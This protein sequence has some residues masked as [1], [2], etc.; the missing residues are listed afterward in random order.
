M[1]YV[2]HIICL[3]RNLGISV[4]FFINLL[5]FLGGLSL[6]GCLGPKAQK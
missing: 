1:T 6:S 4:V 5:S 2:G 3:I